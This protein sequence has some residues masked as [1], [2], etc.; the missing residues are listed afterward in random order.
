MKHQSYVQG[1]RLNAIYRDYA[2]YT[3]LR[4]IHAIYAQASCK[5][6]IS[7]PEA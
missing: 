3:A 4:A 7:G 5:K 6:R 2:A 1:E